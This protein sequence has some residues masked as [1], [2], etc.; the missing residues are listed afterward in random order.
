LIHFYKR[1][2]FLEENVEFFP[3]CS[4]MAAGGHVVQQ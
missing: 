2:F 4:E 3:I 1:T